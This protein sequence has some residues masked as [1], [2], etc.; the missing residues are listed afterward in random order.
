MEELISVIV[1]VYNIERYLSK[2]LET[3][4]AQSYQNLE[5]ILVDDGS[6]DSSG[7]ICNTF[8]EKDSRTTVIH[9]QN[10]GL[11]AAR[12]SGQKI[13]KG[14]YLMF[15][16]GDDYMHLDTLKIMIE[17]FHQY[18]QSD[19]VFVD[20]IKTDSLEENIETKKNYNTSVLSQE[21]LI[22]QLFNYDGFTGIIPSA[23][24]KLYKRE[25]LEGIWANDYPRAQDIDFNIRVFLRASCAT[26]I[27]YKLYFWVQRPTSFM[28]QSNYWTI[29]YP[30]TVKMF[31]LNYIHLRVDKRQYGHYLLKKLY[32]RMLFY[33][34]KFYKT[35]QQNNVFKQCYEYEKATRKDYWLNRRINP[36]EKV[37]VTVL[38]HCPRLTHWLMKVTKNC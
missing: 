1:P 10:Q 2:C 34:N 25:I 28:H 19:L 16:D 30:C 20:F 35:D 7:Q 24:N 11:W 36:I 33:K 3:I 9:Q 8:A 6:T 27:H 17:V 37:A 38:L 18:P 29:A 14:D 22:H 15:V 23:W 32:R 21:Q 5:I 31:F 4:A 12:N 13:A 26:W